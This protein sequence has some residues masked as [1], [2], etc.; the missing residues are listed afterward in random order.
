MKK[1]IL[2]IALLVMCLPYYAF[3]IPAT[4]LEKINVEIL[5]KK[6]KLTLM[7]NGDISDYLSFELTNPARLVIDFPFDK[8]KLPQVYQLKN[9]VYPRIRWGIFKGKLRVVVDCSLKRL[10]F[11]KIE[12]K[13]DLLLIFLQSV[14]IKVLLS[15]LSKVY[16]FLLLSKLLF[17]LV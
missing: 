3:A 10:P 12:I 5:E 15:K 11:Y 14:Y 6:L 2:I 8:C 13:V 7:A 4:S 1:R 17:H 16:P 9:K